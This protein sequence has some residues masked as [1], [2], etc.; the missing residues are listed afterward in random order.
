[1]TAMTYTPVI[2]IHLCTALAAVVVGAAMF[3]QRKGT[4]L[5][6]LAGRLWI[7]LMAVTALVSFGIRTHGHF[8]WIHLLSLLTLYTIG[9]AVWSI[10]SRD[11]ARHRRF[12][13]GAYTGLVIAGLFTLLPGRRLGDLV[14]HA[15]NLV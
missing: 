4:P 3:L 8:S 14:W 15:F 6:R 12:V 5:H 11:I 9:Q 2:L 13:T 1:M 7:G 10:R